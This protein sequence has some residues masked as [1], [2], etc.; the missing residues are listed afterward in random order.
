MPQAP[1]VKY[2]HMDFLKKYDETFGAKPLPDLINLIKSKRRDVILSFKDAD[3][4]AKIFF[5]KGRVNHAEFGTEKGK[6][7]FISIYNLLGGEFVLNKNTGNYQRTISQ[8]IKSL[9]SEAAMLKGNSGSEAVYKIAR[10]S[11]QDEAFAL[12]SDQKSDPTNQTKGKPKKEAKIQLSPATAVAKNSKVAPVEQI[13]HE[14]VLKPAP[15]IK[16][17]VK[18]SIQPRKT[19]AATSEEEKP[20]QKLTLLETTMISHALDGVVEYLMEKWPESDTIV[21]SKSIPL[22]HLTN[23]LHRHIAFRID[24]FLKKTIESRNT[25]FD[26]HNQ[27]VDTALQELFK[28]LLSHWKISR[29]DF[30]DMLKLAVSFELAYTYDPA[31]A[32]AEFVYEQCGKKAADVKLVLQKMRNHNL[33]GKEIEP[34]FDDID[35]QPDRAVHPRRLEHLLR[36]IYN[37]LK[38][39]ESI[40]LV[41]SSLGR[42]LDI[43]NIGK[44]SKIDHVQLNLF[45]MVLHGHGLA[46]YADVLSSNPDQKDHISLNE[47]D[48]LFK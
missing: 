6:T 30:N 3:Q 20:P 8:P 26:L 16:E 48:S 44:F 31:R 12:L 24:L 45:E 21:S 15:S 34:I 32:L 37:R 2:N 41:R 36:A 27:N 5:Q 7:A 33:I 23:Y 13:T 17:Q 19:V 29:V 25:P 47:F 35:K 11:A 28:Q 14:P 1:L 46:H 43:M 22:E 40:A 18:G 39:K 9:L 4:G 42:M 10:E 38:Q